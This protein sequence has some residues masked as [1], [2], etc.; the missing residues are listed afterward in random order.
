MVID[1]SPIIHPPITIESILNLAWCFHLIISENKFQSELG[2]FAK[3]Y[4]KGMKENYKKD[5]T[6]LI[7]LDNILYL[8]LGYIQNISF[9]RYTYH[10]YRMTLRKNREES[11]RYWNEIANV[12]SLSN[13]GIFLRIVS[14]F[15]GGLP[16]LS[17][18]QSTLTSSIPPNFE[19][20]ILFIIFGLI[21]L[22]PL[23]ILLKYL[24]NWQNKKIITKL[25][26]EEIFF[27]KII[28]RP[29]YRDNMKRLFEDTKNLY[30][31]YYP[32]YYE[33]IE[34][35]DD[36]IIDK[37][38]PSSTFFDEMDLNKFMQIH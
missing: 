36:K 7:F 20:L 26:Q 28:G 35:M 25:I 2:I 31:M 11:I 33:I 19:I 10:L 23:T 34:E 8:T 4:F 14:F 17:S 15:I 38:I 6:A 9:G 37:I 32:K 29:N 16:A 18:G 1:M 13:E 30:K 5:D 27:W 3:N 21:S 24:R 12:T 22:I